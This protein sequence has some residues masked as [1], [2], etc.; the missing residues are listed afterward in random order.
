MTAGTEVVRPLVGKAGA[1]ALPIVPADARRR[2]V[3]LIVATVWLGVVILCALFAPLLPLPSPVLPTGAAAAAPDLTLSG[4]LGT[5]GFGRSVM[6]RL[7]NGARVSLLV[8]VL[9]TL[10][11]FVIGSVLGLLA[12]FLRGVTDTVVSYLADTML[13]F[14]PLVLLLALSSVLQPSLQTILIALTLL[15]IPTFVRLARANTM[16]WASRDF[17][18]AAVNVGATRTRI[19][20]REILPN[21]LPSLAAYLPLVV[22]A[23]IVA[24]GSLSFLGYGI[25][26]PTPSWGGMVSDAR[27]YISTKPLLVFIPAATICLTVFSLNI[28][29]DQL[30]ARFRSVVE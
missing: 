25:P 18:R 26:S 27:D 20:V 6:S 21:V 17:V 11:G 7:L 28:I 24:E 9:A 13:A 19:M 14:P 1:G 16:R 5:D 23:M 4:L 15:V 2:P 10:A 30:Q 8:G 3:L 22:A 12:G 29:G